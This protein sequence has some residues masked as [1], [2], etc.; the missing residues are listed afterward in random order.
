MT[1]EELER[2]RTAAREMT[3]VQLGELRS[4]GR[5]AFQPGVWEVLDNELG[6]RERSRARKRRAEERRMKASRQ[7]VSEVESA[8]PDASVRSGLAA[9][10]AFSAHKSIELRRISLV[11]GGQ[12]SGLGS[13]AA[14]FI[15]RFR[16]LDAALSRLFDLAE[17]DT[18]VSGVMAKHGA[19]RGRLQELY[20]MLLAGGAGHWAGDH[21]VASSSLVYGQ[22]LDYALTCLGTGGGGTLL[23]VAMRLVEYFERG[24]VGPVS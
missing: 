1:P 21:F 9:A 18:V 15:E 20:D 13:E 3:D 19:D 23:E 6:F 17:S 4:Q 24:E 11:L 7:A 2:E 12:G 14:N 5:D 22:T 8:E 10:S 16:E